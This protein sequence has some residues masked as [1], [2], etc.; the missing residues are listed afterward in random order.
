MKIKWKI[1][2]LT[3][4]Y[5]TII[6]LVAL[7]LFKP[8]AYKGSNADITTSVP[9]AVLKCVFSENNLTM[10]WEYT[11]LNESNSLDAY[12]FAVENNCSFVH[13]RYKLNKS[14]EEK[15]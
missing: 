1:V 8:G 6:I 5:L 13:Q 7:I 3:I 14:E 11:Y 10:S 2:W 12:R 15:N 4:M 9:D